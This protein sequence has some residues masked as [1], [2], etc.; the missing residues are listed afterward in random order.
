MRASIA[1]VSISE[2]LESKLCAVAQAGFGG[3]EI[4]ENDRL[5]FHGSPREIGSIIKD[6]GLL[7]TMFQPYRDFE[8]MADD[9]GQRT[10]DRMERKFDVMD[11]LGT[12]LVLLCSSCSRIASGD[13]AQTIDDLS[14]L[15]ERAAK[16]NM[17][18][19][20]EALAWGWHVNDHREAWGIVRDVDHQAFRA[21]TLTR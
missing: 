3:V 12:D 6:L 21:G 16:R 9:L 15:G 5:G 8:G 1:T 11:A 13:R 19:G 4:F 14:A 10:F 2:T 17:R 7:C 20:Y 18:V